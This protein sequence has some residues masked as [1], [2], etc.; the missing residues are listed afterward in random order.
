MACCL[1]LP[2]ALASHH[3]VFHVSVFK[4]YKEEPTLFPTRQFEQPRP[5]W[6]DGA[7]EY[8]VEDVLYWKLVSFARGPGRTKLYRERFLVKWKGYPAYDSMW[9]PYENF[10]AADGAINDKFLAFLD[11]ERRGDVPVGEGGIV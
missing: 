8:E 11:R 7:A 10:V 6:I 5:I 2:P 1:D 9:E 4:P 3:P